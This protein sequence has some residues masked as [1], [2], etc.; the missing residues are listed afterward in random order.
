MKQVKQRIRVGKGL[1]EGTEYLYL[2]KHSRDRTLRN[3]EAGRIAHAIAYTHENA[4]VY[5]NQEWKEFRVKASGKIIATVA[6]EE[7]Q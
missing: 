4:D 2:H 6:V 7:I 5:Y 1:G 3:P